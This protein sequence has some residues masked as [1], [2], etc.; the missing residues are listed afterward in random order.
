V[1][2]DDVVVGLDTGDDLFSVTG[3]ASGIGQAIFKR[4]AM[5]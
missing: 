4:M 5:V 3:A 2:V 1:V